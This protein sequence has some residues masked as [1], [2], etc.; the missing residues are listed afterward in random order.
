MGFFSWK[1][2]VTGNQIISREYKRV[3][4]LV[5]KEFRKK[6]GVR[7]SDCCYDGYGHF[8]GHDIYELI[9]EW[10]RFHLSA[11]LLGEKPTIDE[12][13]GLE[14]YEKEYLRKQGVSEEEIAKRD[15]DKQKENYENAFAERNYIAAIMDEYKCGENNASLSKK[16][17]NEWLRDIGTA[18]DLSNGKNNMLKYPIKITYDG[19]AIYEECGSSERDNE[20]GC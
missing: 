5:P 4:V 1:D 11:E 17:G 2:C 20:Q 6:Y 3:Y 19:T 12:Y 8:G 9:A 18:I 13:G 7:I 14:S 10:N 15:L 16:Y